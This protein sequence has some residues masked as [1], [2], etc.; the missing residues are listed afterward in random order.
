MS[1]ALEYTWADKSCWIHT[2][3]SFLCFINIFWDLWIYQYTHQVNFGGRILQQS[4]QCVLYYYQVIIYLLGFSFRNRQILESSWSAIHKTFTFQHKTSVWQ[5]VWTV[6][7]L[8]EILHG[9]SGAG[10]PY[11][12]WLLHLLHSDGVQVIGFK[13]PITGFLQFHFQFLF[14]CKILSI[15]LKTNYPCFHR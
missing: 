4:I 11:S 12:T 15:H 10:L 9:S 2:A 8:R 13:V 3:V 7:A 1:H 5:G 14:Y 6:P